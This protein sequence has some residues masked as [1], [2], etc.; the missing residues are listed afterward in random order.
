MR[1]A[2][3][4]SSIRSCAFLLPQFSLSLPVRH[5]SLINV[6]AYRAASSSQLNYTRGS[7]IPLALTIACPDSQALDLLSAPSGVSLHLLREIN[8]GRPELA[9]PQYTPKV[10]LFPRPLR[11]RNDDTAGTI[12]DKGRAPPRYKTYLERSLVAST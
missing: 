11:S 5:F 7:I 10:R 2:L 3:D 1:S 9:I 8:Y 12:C 4:P 6:S